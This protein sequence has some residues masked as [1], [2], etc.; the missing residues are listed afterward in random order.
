MTRIRLALPV[1][2]LLVSLTLPSIGQ[3]SDDTRKE[4]FVPPIQTQSQVSTATAN[5]AERQMSDEEKGDLYMA[6]KQYARRRINT[7]CCAGKTR[8]TPCF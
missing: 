3:T 7:E 4:A 5:P 6:R 1:S 8:T 2:F